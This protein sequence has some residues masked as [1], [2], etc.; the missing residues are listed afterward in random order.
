MHVSLW[1]THGKEQSQVALT[2]ERGALQ[3]NDRKKWI[4]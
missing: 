3:I 4:G 2:E 1:N